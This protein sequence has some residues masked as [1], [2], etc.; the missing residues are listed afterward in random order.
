MYVAGRVSLCCHVTAGTEYHY[1]CV[2]A[3]NYLFMLIRPTLVSAKSGRVSVVRCEWFAAS[4]PQL[5][6]SVPG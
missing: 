1:V 6:E 4:A 3:A 5:Y 2:L